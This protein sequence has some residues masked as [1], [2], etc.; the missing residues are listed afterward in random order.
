MRIIGIDPGTNRTGYGIVDYQSGRFK[1]VHYGCIMPIDSS[2]FQQKILSICNQVES[3]LKTYQPSIAVV[4]DIF[5]AVNPQ[6]ALKLGH[7]RGALM[8][9]VSRLNIGLA[10]LTALEIKKGI[11]GY[12]RADK[13]QVAEMVRVILG[14]DA[15]PEYEDTTD[16][17]A[18]A[19]VYAVKGDYE[20]TIMKQYLKKI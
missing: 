10:E 4:E 7:I 5:Y 14:L 6:S 2:T 3:V 8:M 17:L 16:A 15:M 20:N 19:I 13:H 18:A 9:T 12:G 1:T 11:T